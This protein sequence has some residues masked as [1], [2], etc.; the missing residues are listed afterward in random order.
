MTEP[1]PAPREEP[2]VVRPE[3]L[4]G[5]E[6]FEAGIRYLPPIT[7]ALIVLNV[8][9]FVWQLSP[10]V[11]HGSGGHMASNVVSHAT[12]S[13][14]ASGAIFGM[15]GAVIVFLVR[16]RDRYEV[17]DKRVPL[18]I[19]VWAGVTVLIGLGIPFIDNGAHVGGFIAGLVVG[20]FL[21][22]AHPTRSTSARLA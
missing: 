22:P 10:S 5:G 7:T 14:G 8:G 11:L 19:A 15:M 3:M 20:S 17:Q 4:A 18:V 16:H 6:D 1:G 12:P 9:M 2:L 13:V 21:E